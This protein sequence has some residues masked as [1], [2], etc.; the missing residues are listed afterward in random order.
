VILHFAKIIVFFFGTV[1]CLIAETPDQLFRQA[2]NSS[3]ELHKM[4]LLTRAIQNNQDSYWP[5]LHMAYHQRGLLYNKMGFTQEALEDFNRSLVYFDGFLQSHY[6]RAD[7]FYKKGQWREVVEELTLVERKNPQ[8]FT[9]FEERGWANFQIQEYRNA[10]KDLTQA[11]RHGNQKENI[12]VLKVL[13]HINIFD[14]EGSLSELSVLKNKLEDPALYYFLRGLLY[15][16]L[17]RER[18]WELYQGQINLL[19]IDR[20]KKLIDL[21]Q[22]LVDSFKEAHRLGFTF[23]ADALWQQVWRMREYLNDFLQFYEDVIESQ[24]GNLKEEG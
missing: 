24:E 16:L 4:N 18:E 14:Y 9:L 3:S 12:F 1:L 7:I 19:P 2:E 21:E 22:R 6:E 15:Y 23:E 17:M 5:F 20:D 10:L 11:I 8:L 13:S